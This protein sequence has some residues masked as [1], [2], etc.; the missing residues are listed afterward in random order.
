MSPAVQHVCHLYNPANDCKLP[1]SETKA[2]FGLPDGRILRCIWAG[3]GNALGLKVG[4][5]TAMSSAKLSPAHHTEGVPRRVARAP[6]MP[7][8]SAK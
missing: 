1:A 8:S 3:T 5:Q 2:H 6:C 7:T 4:G